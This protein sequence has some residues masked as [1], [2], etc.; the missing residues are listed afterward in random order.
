SHLFQRPDDRD[1]QF[2]PPLAGFRE[3]L[4][5]TRGPETR[6]APAMRRSR[7]R[8]CPI[9]SSVSPVAVERGCPRVVLLPATSVLL[10]LPLQTRPSSAVRCSNPPGRSWG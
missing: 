2:N 10:P 1:P 9:G 4:S 6:G 3:L 5:A 8:P 7:A